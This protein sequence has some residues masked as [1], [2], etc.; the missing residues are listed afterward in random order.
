MIE[1]H[2]KNQRHARER[3]QGRVKFV[4]LPL[5]EQ[6][7]G[8]AGM[9]APFEQTHFAAQAQLPEFVPHVILMRCFIPRWRDR[10]AALCS[11]PST[12]GSIFEE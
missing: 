5:R 2:T 10:K 4:A 3:R 1:A 9:F 8:K 12:A 11:S 7:G 6:R